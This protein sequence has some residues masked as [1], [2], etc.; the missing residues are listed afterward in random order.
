[1][2]RKAAAGNAG[3]AG[4]AGTSGKPRLTNAIDV[5]LQAQVDAQLMEQ[6][7]FAPLEYLI[8]SGRLIYSDY[9]SW[10]R[11]EIETLDDVLMGSRE[12]ILAEIT[13]AVNYA[14]SIGLVEQT[15][16]FHSWTAE[17][18]VSTDAAAGN[19]AA[20][21]ASSASASE[22]Q[23]GTSRPSQPTLLR[24]SA[25]PQVHRLLAGRH[26]PAQNAPQMDLFFD[27]P[28]VALTNGI[29]RALAA[30]NI[31]DAEQ[32]IDRLYQ[33]A[34]NH[35][36]LASFDR[37]L[38]ALT[39]LNLPIADAQAELDFLLDITPMAKRLLG[40]EA[41]D[42]L[43]PLW[44]HL[45]DALDGRAFSPDHADL[46]RS[47]ALTQAQDWPAVSASVLNELAWQ[48]HPTLCL[49]LA[50]SSFYRRRRTEAL[51]AWCHLCWRAPKQAEEALDSRR[52]ADSEIA[53]L[54][55]KFLELDEEE[56]A[57]NG[58]SQVLTPADFPAFLLLHQPDLAQH[59][60]ADLP[61]GNTPGE[62]HYRCV[63]RW[64]QAHRAR[65]QDEEMA[66]RKMLQASQ[67]VL[68][69]YLKRTVDAR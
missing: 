45:A 42:L 31:S 62:A 56:S 18:G 47:F 38:A 32:Q 48:Q 5:A 57:A 26:I 20:P 10:R 43:S 19:L 14:R 22:I 55:Q 4:K 29:A 24:L 54:W 63:H 65:H 58:E 15:Q 9:E 39:H 23:T 30:R 69:G 12:K 34:P 49:R 67:P 44:R 61:T 60:S 7:A 52:Q 13:Q 25:D 50:Q 3:T 1:M 59:L 41:R 40:S 51:T 28:V 11:R 64:I 16:E 53:G 37:L 2:S 27:N 68:F 21:Y 6:G 36:D 46:H 35:A 8:D 33:Q 66:Q 17:M